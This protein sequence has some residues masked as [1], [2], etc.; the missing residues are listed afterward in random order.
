[1]KAIFATALTVSAFLVIGCSSSGS[2]C[3]EGDACDDSNGVGTDD[4]AVTNPPGGDT[5]APTCADVGKLHP[6]LG[7]L[8]LTTDRIDSVAGTDRA[9]TKPHSALVEEY[10]RVL[11]QENKPGTIDGSGATFGLAAARWYQEPQGSAV[12]LNQAY[13]VAFDGCLR[14]TGDIEGGS[15]NP[16]YGT[17]PSADTA[18]TECAAWARKF[19]SRDATPEEID[20]CVA[21]AVTDSIRE[22][23]RD[24]IGTRDTSSQRRWAYAC[25]SVLTSTGFLTY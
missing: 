9:R 11:G 16:K 23:Y 6:G 8:E 19:W 7:G 3:L 25:A 14:L 22:T 4:P 13:S 18:K 12:V 21:V 10:S 20:S 1:M 2:D 17:A 24:P 15:A 5:V